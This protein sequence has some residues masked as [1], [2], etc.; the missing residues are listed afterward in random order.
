MKIKFDY[1]E[2]FDLVEIYRKLTAPSKPMMVKANE[3]FDEPY[4]DTFHKME[5]LAEKMLAQ[6]K[7]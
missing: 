6:V 5:A 2:E 3:F 7:A 1:N 4:D